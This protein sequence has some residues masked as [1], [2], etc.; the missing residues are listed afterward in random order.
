MSKKYVFERKKTTFC[1]ISKPTVF[2]F[3]SMN[4]MNTIN[5]L[6]GSGDENPTVEKNKRKLI[7]SV[8]I[9]N[10]YIVFLCLFDIKNRKL[11]GTFCKTL[12]MYWFYYTINSKAWICFNPK[13]PS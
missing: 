4:L 13:V 9:P 2:K 1:D 11:T 3:L 10:L 8:N 5:H 12:K 6:L 7:S